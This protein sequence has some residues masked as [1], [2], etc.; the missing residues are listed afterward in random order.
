MPS[1]K[2]PMGEH[3]HLL[4]IYE[5]EVEVEYRGERYRVR[6]NGG[7]YRLNEFRK[8]ARP[9]DKTW[10]FGRQNFTTGYHLLAGVPIHRIVCSA[11]N[12][13]PPS[14][15]HVVDHIDTNRANNRPEKLRWL[16]RLENALLNEITARRIELAYGS[17][18]AFLEDPSRPLCY[19]LPL[20]LCL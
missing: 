9:L 20:Q 5:T 2:T 4:E 3:D 15:K 19:A 1:S 14:D 11:F 12:G 16:T 17:I 6:D 10:T 13:P 7:A 18:E 8:R